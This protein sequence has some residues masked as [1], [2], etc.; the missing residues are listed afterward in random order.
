MD[1]YTQSEVL[2]LLEAARRESERDWLMFLLAY[3]H[4]LR[5][6]EVTGP[7]GFTKAD[8]QESQIIVRRLKGSL[9]TVQPLRTHENPLLDEK[10]GIEARIQ[11]LPA[12]NRVFPI[13]TVQYWRRFDYYRKKLGLRRLL[14]TRG[15]FKH[16]LAMHIIETAGIENVRQYLGHRSLSSTGEYLRVTDAAASKAVAAA[17]K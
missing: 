6:G 12:R 17:M 16:S 9:T 14:K 5:A 2:Q 11:S 3:N 7:R 15:V 10:T 8:I 13:S 4:G 1:H